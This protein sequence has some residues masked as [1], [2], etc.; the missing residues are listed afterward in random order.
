[1]AK[2][3]WLAPTPPSTAIEIASHRVTVAGLSRLGAKP[4]VSAY[5]SEPLAAEAVVPSPNSTNIPEPPV[6]VDALR[7]ALDRTGLRSASRVALV[8]PDSVARVTL[9]TFE[10]LPPKAAELEQLIRWQLKKAMPFPIDEATV[11]SF[12]ANTTEQGITVAAIV[13]RRDIIAEYEGVVSALGIHAGVVDLASFNVMNAIIAGGAA[14][15]DSLVVTLAA[16]ATSLAILRGGDLMFYR[17]RAAVD[18]EPLSAL[19]HQTAMY[20]EDRLGGTRFGRVWLSGSAFVGGAAQ[21]RK[22]IGEHLGTPAETVD[23]TSIIQ[24][25]DPAGAPQDVLDALAAPIGLL[26]RER[27]AA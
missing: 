11:S 5:A 14:A 21:A 25:R 15:G 6:V 8:L 23:V 19:V 18:E 2:M 10:K 12:V 13:A 3:S 27:E 22:G 26:L 20:H 1:M 17:H 16:E 9:L 24:F 7:R 4:T